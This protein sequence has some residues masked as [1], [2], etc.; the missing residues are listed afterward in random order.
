MPS[1]VG[2]GSATAS[3]A[4]GATS[5]ISTGAGGGVSIRMGV[6]ATGSTG[7]AR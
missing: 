5:A 4:A 2:V 1:T 3:N 6:D 7:A